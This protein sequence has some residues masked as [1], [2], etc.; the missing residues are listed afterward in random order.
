MLIENGVLETSLEIDNVNF[1]KI[2]HVIND[3]YILINIVLTDFLF[4]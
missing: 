1:S 2:V 3:L 4:A